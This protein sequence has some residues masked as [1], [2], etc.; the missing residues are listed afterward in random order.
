MMNERVDDGLEL[1]AGDG[2]PDGALL[3]IT[4]DNDDGTPDGV[5][6]GI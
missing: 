4:F 6:L 3:G 5:L 2:T 1:G